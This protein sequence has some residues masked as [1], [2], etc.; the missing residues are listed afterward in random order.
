M[1]CGERH[2]TWRDALICFLASSY[3]GVA[4]SNSRN[5]YRSAEVKREARHGNGIFVPEENH[6]CSALL[7]PRVSV[8][9][10]I[11]LVVEEEER[12]LALR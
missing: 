6:V 10:G 1:S 11:E 2:A 3:R 8:R 9:V 4:Y 7:V 12:P 5:A